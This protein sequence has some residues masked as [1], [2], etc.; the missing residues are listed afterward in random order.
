MIR[1]SQ[2]EFVLCKFY[3]VELSKNHNTKSIC[4]EFIWWM[5]EKKGGE[6]KEKLDIDGP[7]TKITP[8]RFMAMRQKLHIAHDP[9]SPDFE[10][11]CETLKNYFAGAD[12][13]GVVAS[14]ELL[15]KERDLNRLS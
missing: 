11:Q 4:K 1:I 13:D 15:A 12:Q 5:V 8:E 6:L 14:S 2:I 10:D 7:E 9:N 3:D